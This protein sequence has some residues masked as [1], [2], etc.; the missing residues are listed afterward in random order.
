MTSNTTFEDCGSGVYRITSE[1]NNPVIL[2]K[3]PGGNYSI[4]ETPKGVFFRRV[5]SFT[6]PPR[7]YGSANDLTER[8][9]KTYFSRPKGTGIHLNG[10]PGSGKTLQAHLICIAMERLGHPTL[11]VNSPMKGDGFNKLLQR[12]HQPCVVLMDEFEKTYDMETDQPFLLTL[13]D[14]TYP[15]HKLFLLTSNN[16]TSVLSHLYDRPGR[17]FYSL[18]YRG[19]SSDVVK[20]YCEDV[21]ID[22]TQTDSVLLLSTMFK[23]FTMDMLTGLV[24]EMNRYGESAGRASALMNLIPDFAPGG[25]Y[26]CEITSPAVTY[27][28]NGYAYDS[29]LFSGRTIELIE[30]GTSNT[31][32]LGGGPKKYAVFGPTSVRGVDPVTGVITCAS[33][34]GALT[35]VFTPTENEEALS[36]ADKLDVY[37]ATVKRV[38]TQA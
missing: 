23:H 10:Q 36:I 27:K 4:E 8:F 25:K 17:I 32:S 22:K 9:L 6:V 20:E 24:E 18:K 35:A 14:G 33:P 2:P 13:L 3:L 1:A 7:I 16:E 12:I 37:Q 11:I 21:L 34:D 28:G 29:P 30:V 31:Q 26:T 38:T 5:K 19:L 15:S